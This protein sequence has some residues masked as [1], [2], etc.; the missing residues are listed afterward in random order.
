[1][2]YDEAAAVKTRPIDEAIRA[3]CDASGKVVCSSRCRWPACG[4]DD[5]PAAIKAARDV[6]L[7]DMPENIE[8]MAQALANHS[9]AYLGRGLVRGWG[10]MQENDREEFRDDARTALAAWR[11]RWGDEG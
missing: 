11:Q 5:I 6:M 8:V 9:N 7:A 1:M 4:C 10:A 3:G 2:P